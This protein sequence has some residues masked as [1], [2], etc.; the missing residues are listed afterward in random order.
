MIKN[1]KKDFSFKVDTDLEYLKT[2][3]FFDIIINKKY[4]FKKRKDVRRRANK[5]NP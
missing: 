4:Q 3:K 2:G 1:L 5:L